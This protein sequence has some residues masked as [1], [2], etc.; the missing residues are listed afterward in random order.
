VSF[1]RLNEA[2]VRV[3]QKNGCE[4]VIPAGQ[5]CCGALPVHAGMRDVGRRAARQNIDA[6]LTGNFDAVISNAAGCGSTLK[7]YGE[8][9]EG[10]AQYAGKAHQFSKLTRDVNEFLA[11]ITLNPLMGKVEASATY[12]DSCHLLHGQKIKAAPRKLL[13]QVPGLDFREM[14]KSDICCGSAGIYNVVQNEMAMEVLRD[15]MGNVNSTK[16]EW[17]V[18]ANPGCML[19]LEAGARLHGHGQRVMHV[20]EVLDQAYAAHSKQ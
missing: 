16:A 3:L 19:Q 13:A 4:V 20:I 10:D 11:S 18:T 12:Q 14:P 7:E 5:T 1:A 2:T 9:L 17:I 6:I 8:L 15:K